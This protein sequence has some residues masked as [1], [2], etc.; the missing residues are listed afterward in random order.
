AIEAA[1]IGVKDKE[2]EV[3]NAAWKLFEEIVKHGKG[4]DEAIE[5][6]SIGIKD[7]NYGVRAATQFL[8]EL[9]EENK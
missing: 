2:N 8:I 9:I 1:S 3:R 5:A 7:A 4:I 6:A